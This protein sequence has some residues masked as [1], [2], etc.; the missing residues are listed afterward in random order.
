MTPMTT[1]VQRIQCLLIVFEDV[2]VIREI[3]RRCIQILMIR[4]TG[5]D[6]TNA[7]I[8]AKTFAALP[9]M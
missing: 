5:I 7:N 2:V 4:P 3:E 8:L 9:G 6:V 1:I